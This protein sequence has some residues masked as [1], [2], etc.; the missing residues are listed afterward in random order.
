MSFRVL[1]NTLV[2]CGHHEKSETVIGTVTPRVFD[3][4]GT[5]F[6]YP[7]NHVCEGIVWRHFYYEQQIK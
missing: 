4:C 5:N 2:W 7:M 3:V 1:E 6:I